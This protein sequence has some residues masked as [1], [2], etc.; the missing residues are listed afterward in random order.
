MTCSIELVLV[1]HTNS[2]KTTLARTLLGRDIGEVR[3]AAHVTAR[4]EVHVMLQ[5]ADGDKLLLWDTPGFGD[6]ARLVRRLSMWDPISWF[7]REVVDRVRDRAFWLSQH[8]L[9]AVRDSGDVVLYLV[10]AAERPQDIGYLEPEMRLLEW[11]DKPVLVLLNQ[12]GP[13]RPPL[14]E[15][16]EHAQ[17]RTHLEK[18]PFVRQVLPMDAFARCWVHEGVL[19]SAVAACLPAA[20]RQPMEKLVGRWEQHNKERFASS[21]EALADQLAE[22]ARDAEP[23]D[24]PAPG[25]LTSALQTVGIGGGARQ[26]EEKAMARLLTRLNKGVGRAVAALLVLHRLDPGAAPQ[27]VKL[28]SRHFVVKAPVDE[29]QAALLGAILSGA[30]T[31]LG[32]DMAAGGLT[33]GTGALVGGV[34][35]AIG[36]FGA[37]RGYNAHGGCREGVV[38]LADDFLRSL[39][40]SCVLRYLAVAHYGR[41]RGKFIESEAPSFWQDE[42]EAAVDRHDLAALWPQLREGAGRREACDLLTAVSLDVLARLYPPMYDAAG[43]AVPSRSEANLMNIVK[44]CAPASDPP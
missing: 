7:L 4:P 25:L 22:A 44:G 36:F 41:G 20:K 6:S 10:N 17:W 23:L 38:T 16:A 27:I 29:K 18:Y 9:R 35:G 28:L 3:D 32:A 31:G 34:L 8:A 30:G 42:V 5:D 15:Q 24:E 40:V 12:S 11:L 33:L 21:M 39:F 19:L 13:P 14:E 26:R 37:T 43:L 1:S 2:G